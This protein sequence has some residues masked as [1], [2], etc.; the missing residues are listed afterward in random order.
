ML[1]Y[2]GLGLG[3]L[4]V[5]VALA[6]PSI[7]LFADGFGALL[8]LTT[9]I[10]FSYLIFFSDF[11]TAEKRR[12]QLIF[13]LFC[14]ACLFWSSLRPAGFATSTADFASHLKRRG[15]IAAAFSYGARCAT[16]GLIGDTPC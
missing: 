6:R 15:H 14:A 1:R 2:A 8:L 11:T 5:L 16:Y 10:I 12:I 3:A 7:S 13:V 9:I 4:V